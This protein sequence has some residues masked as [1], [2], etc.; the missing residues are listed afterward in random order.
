MSCFVHNPDIFSSLSQRRKETRSCSLFWKLESKKC[1]YFC[2][3]DYWDWSTDDQTSVLI[4]HNFSSLSSDSKPV[5]LRICYFILAQ[6]SSFENWTLSLLVVTDLKHK[7][8][9][10]TAVCLQHPGGGR[11]LHQLPVKPTGSCLSSRLTISSSS[12]IGKHM[13]FLQYMILQQPGSY[14]LS[15]SGATRKFLLLT[16]KSLSMDQNTVIFCTLDPPLSSQYLLHT[17]RLSPAVLHFGLH[18]LSVRGAV[19]NET[20]NLSIKTLPDSLHRRH[21]YCFCLSLI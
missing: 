1:I 16:D 20:V 11:R 7:L 13:T 15:S 12:C 9:L 4:Y 5:V 19:N 14:T 8:R 10:S 2:L 18:S 17:D 3:K 6:S 21:R